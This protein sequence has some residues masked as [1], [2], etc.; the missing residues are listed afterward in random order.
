MRNP[1]N[2]PS[3]HFLA[4]FQGELAGGAL[5]F[6]SA[7][8]AVAVANADSLAPHYNHWL[9]ASI[10]IVFNDQPFA[11]SI[12]HLIS[13]GLMALFFL[14]VGLEIKREFISGE[15][16]SR[17]VAILPAIAAAGGMLIPALIYVGFNWGDE[18]NLRGWA[19]PTATDIAFSLGVLS[20]LGSRVPMSV[21][22]FLTAVAIIDDVGAIAI[23]ALFYTKDLN[24]TAFMLALAVI[25][26][27]YI[28]NRRGVTSRLPYMIGFLALWGLLLVSG[29]HATLAG[30]AVAMTIPLRT[31]DNLNRSPLVSL[32]H[33]LHSLVTFVI[34][35]LFAFANAGVDLTNASLSSLI[36]PIPLGI[37]VGLVLG[38]SIGI[39]L[40]VWLATKLR[41][42]VM[43]SNCSWTTMIGIAFL[44]GIGFTVSLFIGNLAFG[45]ESENINLVKLGVLSGSILAG[46]IG[47]LFLWLG[48]T[49]KQR[50]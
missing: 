39:S 27:L 18:N 8:L 38:K 10:G 23:I 19:I 28:F 50:Q 24:I 17:Q 40:A 14:L 47:V 26:L 22:V 29:V 7:L 41:L 44:C 9:H 20:L 48:A 30:V 21:K 43:P 11:F 4:F 42:S 34:L 32:E 37:A 13:D 33:D 1:D 12:K 3:K 35:P 31:T 5:L 49:V 6:L 2:R 16:A 25:F 45:D 46:V 36:H 15:L